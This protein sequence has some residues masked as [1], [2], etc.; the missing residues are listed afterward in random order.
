MPRAEVQSAVEVWLATPEAADHLDPERLSP[1]DRAAWAAIRTPRRRQDWASS[2][3]LL[4]AAAPAAGLARSLSHSRGYAALAVARGTA[5]IGVDVEWLAPRDFVSLADLAFDPREAA[6]L[7]SLP[8]PATTCA[9][10]YETWT[11]KEAF[12]KALRLPLAAALRQCTRQFASGADTL[13]LPTEQPWRAIV[14]APR[15]ELR[16]ALAVVGGDVTTATNRVR[17]ME[18]PPATVANWP[19][20]Q[21]W[22]GAGR[23]ARPC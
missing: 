12:A 2:R 18:W 15:P 23:P 10:F 4:A 22:R 19:I 20:V 11:L 9:S 17:T 8:D 6:G 1:A 5:S 13:R 14:Y 3:A 21:Q 16:L 7:A